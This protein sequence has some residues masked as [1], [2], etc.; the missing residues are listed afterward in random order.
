MNIL[1]SIH[2]LSVLFICLLND[3]VIAVKSTIQSLGNLR[4][5]LAETLAR[6]S[7][8]AKRRNVQGEKV[9]L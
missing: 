6:E 2:V 3:M 7:K 9:V 5:N 4:P 1:Y 8:S